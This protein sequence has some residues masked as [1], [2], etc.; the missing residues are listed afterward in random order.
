MIDEFE[1]K[2]KQKSKE[3]K[4]NIDDAL[5]TMQ[6]QQIALDQYEKQ[7]ELDKKLYDIAKQYSEI[8]EENKKLA[9][10]NQKLLAVIQT[11]TNN[12]AELNSLLSAVK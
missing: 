12:E 1:N 4:I 11:L 7:N 9:E 6:Y 2:A 3:L 10:E 5:N 8:I